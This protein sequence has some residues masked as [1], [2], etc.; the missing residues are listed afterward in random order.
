MPECCNHPEVA[1]N[2]QECCQSMSEGAD[3]DCFEA[4]F[5]ETCTWRIFKVTDLNDTRDFNNKK[6]CYHDETRRKYKDGTDKQI[7]DTICCTEYEDFCPKNGKTSLTKQERIEK[8]KRTTLKQLCDF[9]FCPGKITK[10][11]KW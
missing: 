1:E 10:G 4:L 7:F 8:A 9:N 5:L 11:K 6:C 3:Q 2:F